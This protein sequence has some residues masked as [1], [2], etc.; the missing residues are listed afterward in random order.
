MLNIHKVIVN[1]SP[2]M[3]TNNHIYASQKVYFQ[4][5][6]QITQFYAVSCQLIFCS[7][8]FEKYPEIPKFQSMKSSYKLITIFLF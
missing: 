8:F 5:N 1:I 3:H 4:F 6:M 7:S 2:N